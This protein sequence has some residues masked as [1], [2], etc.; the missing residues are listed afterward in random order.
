MEFVERLLVVQRD[1]VCEVMELE[2]VAGDGSR[3]L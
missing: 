1:E 3:G 2:L